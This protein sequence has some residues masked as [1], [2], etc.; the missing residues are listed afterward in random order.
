MSTDR[1]DTRRRI[2]DAVRQLLEA[3]GPEAATLG[4]I[5]RA[6]SVSRQAIY[7]HFD[8]RRGLLIALGRHVDETEGL[9]DEVAA[10]DAAPTARAALDQT[11]DVLVRYAPR[12]QRIAAVLEAAGL[13][14][15]EMAA[16]F[17]D[18]MASRR[19]GFRAMLARLEAAGELRPEWTVDHATDAFWSL[20]AARSYT[21]LVVQRG[22]TVEAYERHLSTAT[23]RLFLV[24]DREGA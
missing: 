12:I 23:E 20:T 8:G 19:R 11:L 7:L 17:E 1:L 4:K 2:L 10:I 15:P 18:R 13:S 6:A 5:A 16:A 9:A 22:W 24:A 14:D 21:E 3:E